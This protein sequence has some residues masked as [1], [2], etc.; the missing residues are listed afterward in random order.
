MKSSG[1]Q[2]RIVFHVVRQGLRGTKPPASSTQGLQRF[3][4]Y[5]VCYH[6]LECGRRKGGVIQRILWN[7]PEKKKK[8]YIY[9]LVSFCTAYQPK[10]Y[11]LAI[12]NSSADLE[13]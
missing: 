8:I 10:I 1:C 3:H 13:M 4:G 5:P 6:P 9:I 7:R 11:Y 12:T 2:E